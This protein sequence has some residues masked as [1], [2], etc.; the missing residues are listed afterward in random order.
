MSFLAKIFGENSK[1]I[2][3]KK[4]KNQLD[5]LICI[6]FSGLG[7]KFI[8]KDTTSITLLKKDGFGELEIYIVYLSKY[9]SIEIEVYFYQYINIIEKHLRLIYGEKKDKTRILSFQILDLINNRDGIAKKMGNMYIVENEEDVVTISKRIFNDFKFVEI[10]SDKVNDIIF[11]DT[12]LNCS[13][14][15]Y[16]NIVYNLSFLDRTIVGLIVAAMDNNPDI[17]KYY[18][19]YN[20]EAIKKKVEYE[21][22][23]N[24]FN[25]GVAYINKLAGGKLNA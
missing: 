1:P 21:D 6:H 4:A 15:K 20:S 13:Y 7:Y 12:L 5:D 10:L 16:L 14:N 2:T 3:F 8:E 9:E 24:D 11:L 18:Q 17:Y 23:F 22:V 19:L 25:L